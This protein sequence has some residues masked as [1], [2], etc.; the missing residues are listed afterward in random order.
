METEDNP[1]DLHRRHIDRI[2]KTIE[3]LEAERERLSRLLTDEGEGE[4]GADQ[5]AAVPHGC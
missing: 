2:D 5:Q 4:T 1:L 3:A